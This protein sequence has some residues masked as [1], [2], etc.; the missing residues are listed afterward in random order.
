MKNKVKYIRSVKNQFQS[1][2][3]QQQIWK[4]CVK[5]PQ[6]TTDLNFGGKKKRQ[7]K[8]NKPNFP[9]CSSQACAQS[10]HCYQKKMDVTSNMLLSHV[11]KLHQQSVHFSHTR[12]IACTQQSRPALVP[13]NP[14]KSFLFFF[15]KKDL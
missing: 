9:I 4:M 6:N 13:K 12:L 11:I 1:L 15:F 14:C 2:P 7:Q 8:E 10:I 3:I 5:I